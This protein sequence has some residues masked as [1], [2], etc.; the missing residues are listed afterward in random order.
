MTRPTDPIELYAWLKQEVS[1][2]EDEMDD[3]KEEV[4]K[5]VDGQGEEVDKGSFVIRSYK[6][7]KYKFSDGYNTKNSELKK[8]RAA[9]I[10]NGTASIDG[11]SEFVK[12]HFKK[13]A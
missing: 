6:R 12:I 1:K 9:E 11:Y 3:L 13:E 10:D 5:T 2:L 7:P 4:F 8:L